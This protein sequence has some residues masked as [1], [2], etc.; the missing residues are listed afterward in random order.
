MALGA[1]ADEPDD[2]ARAVGLSA[3]MTPVLRAALPT[4]PMHCVS[5]PEAGTGK[6]HL[7][8]VAASISTGASCPVIAAGKLT[9]L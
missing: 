2:D 9:S 1:V 3:L 8:H 6:T 4:A 7:T 5:A